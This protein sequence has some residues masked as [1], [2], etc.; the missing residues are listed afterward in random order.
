MKGSNG[1][2]HH[3]NFIGV[4]KLM[5]EFLG[6][7]ALTYVG[8]WAVIYADLGALTRNSVALAHGMILTGF[9]W[10]GGSI[11]GAH[12]NPA[13]TFAT[14]IIKR[15]DWNLAIYY[16]IAQLMGALTAASL[17]FIQ[18]DA[19]TMELLSTKSV[20]G[21][22]GPGSLNYEVSGM[23][24]EVLGTFF[25]TY[26]YMA[27]CVDDN[28]NKVQGIGA[29]AIGMTLYLVIM[30]VGEV[31]GGGLNPARSLGPAIVAGTYGKFQLIHLLGPFIGA[32]IATVLYTYI[33]LSNVEQDGTQRSE[34]EMVNVD[35]RD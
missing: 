35:E 7:L 13:I 20:M 10:F 34:E 14:A 33:Y 15:I 16:M 18:L 21:V 29:P 32:T 23:W 25:L 22:P 3:Q 2:R 9:I 27:T 17:I 31:S 30:T 12:Y 28:P 6:T 24:G 11:S 26:V 1:E 19:S 4:K 8:S 5:V